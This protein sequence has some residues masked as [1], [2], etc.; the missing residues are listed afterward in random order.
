[1]TFTGQP[2]A[3]DPTELARF[4]ALL[5]SH[6]VRRYLEV[7]V[8]YGDT[9]HAIMSALGPSAVGVALDQPGQAWGDVDSPQH[10]L[11]VRL[12]LQDHGMIVYEV[13]GDSGDPA[14]FEQV[15]ALGP[16]DAVFIDADHRYDAVQRDWLTYGTLAPLVAFHDI[17]GTGQGAQVGGAFAPVEVPLLWAELREQFETFEFVEPGSNMGIGV[18]DRGVAKM[19]KR[20]DEDKLEGESERGVKK[21]EKAQREKSGGVPG[22][23]QRSPDNPQP[24]NPNDTGAKPTKVGVP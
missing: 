5:R 17:A 16:Y 14:I 13:T 2:L 15:K 23:E 20:I 1:M 22:R 21:G 7:G 3:Q 19:V 24:K 10:W 12:H 18:V 11:A 8:R 9:F 6:G 4:I